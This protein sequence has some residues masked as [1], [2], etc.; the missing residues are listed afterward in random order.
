MNEELQR[1]YTNEEVYATLKQMFPLKS[2]RP[3]GF[4]AYFY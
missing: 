2:L 3:D 1:P 4:S